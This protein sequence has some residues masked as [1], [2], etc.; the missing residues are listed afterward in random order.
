MRCAVPYNPD[1]TILGIVLTMFDRRNNLSEQVARDVRGFFGDVVLGTAIPRNIRLS[2]AP[3]HGL[4][5][6]RYDPRSAG[7]IAY[8]AMTDE[9]L[10]R[11]MHR[12]G[13]HG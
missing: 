9:I 3:S 13:E 7:A 4:P 11:L 10:E 2:E 6:V 5:I 1:L 8:E 12:R